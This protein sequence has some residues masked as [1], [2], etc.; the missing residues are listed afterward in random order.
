MTGCL[1]HTGMHFRV[2]TAGVSELL[3]LWDLHR[4]WLLLTR[5]TFEWSSTVIFADQQEVLHLVQ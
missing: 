2:Q 1:R 5:P 3:L 4:G